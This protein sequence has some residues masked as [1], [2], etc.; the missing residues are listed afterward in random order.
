MGRLGF[1]FDARFC[2]ACKACQI[3][4]KDKN[5][6]WEGQYFRRVVT[7]ESGEGFEAN[8]APRLGHYS[9]ACNH[10]AKPACIPVCPV[11]AIRRGEDGLVEINAAACIGCGKCARSC[12]Y[13]AIALKKATIDTI[14]AAHSP[15]AP[16]AKCDACGD[17]R[18]QGRNPACVDACITRC[19]EFG[20]LEELKKARGPHLV[21]QLPGLPDPALTEPS[22]LIRTGPSHA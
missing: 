14:G 5:N 11:G 19:L 17:L 2:I 18:R 1:C 7:F 20:D 22:L 16:A 15:R 9:G 6:L 13:H 12:P 10:C 21:Q 8:G 3:A 4:C